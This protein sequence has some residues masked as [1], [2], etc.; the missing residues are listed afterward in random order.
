[1]SE[2]RYYKSFD[3]DFAETRNQDYKLPK[4]YKWIHKNPIYNFFSL[5]LYI[6]VVVLDLV[7]MKL[8]AHTTVKNR[9]LLIKAKL[10]GGYYLYSNHTILFGDVV[11]PFAI[12]FPTHPYIICSP[13]NLGIPVVGKWL[14]MAGALPIPDNLR[15]MKKFTEAVGKRI[16]QRNAIIIYPESHLWQYYT[17]IRPYTEAAF[18]F[19][20]KYSA[21]VYVATSTFKKS[22]FYKKPKITIYLD[23]P[24]YPDDELPRKEAQN[25]LHYMVQK[26]MERRAKHSTYEFISYRKKTS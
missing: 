24:F 8:F 20:F 16:K 5:I 26:T 23:G 18:H 13:S 9:H 10:H 6:L 17:K 1:M 12:T 25:K 14:P 11:N 2:V 4:D 19:P 21:P 3:Q 7:Y 22:L 15:D